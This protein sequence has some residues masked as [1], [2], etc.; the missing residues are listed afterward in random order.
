[1][2]GRDALEKVF[3]AYD[4][5]PIKTILT[6]KVLTHLQ[7]QDVPDIVRAVFHSDGSKTLDASLS[8]VVM[9]TFREGDEVAKEIIQ[10]N[11]RHIGASRSEEHTSELQSRGQLVCRLLLEKKK[12]T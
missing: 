6:E 5:F 1:M 3:L 8:K 4:G 11:A 7:V 9:E 10:R 12:V 2:I